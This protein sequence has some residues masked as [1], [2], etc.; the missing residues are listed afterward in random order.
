MLVM[1]LGLCISW[2]CFIV[3]EC[4]CAS[5]TKD[6][7]CLC[8]GFDFAPKLL[9][10]CIARLMGLCSWC[11]CFHADVT[12]KVEFSVCNYDLGRGLRG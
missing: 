7:W 6:A 9:L 2:I 8:A 5:T 3:I 4:W 1:A 11:V 12:A 10:A